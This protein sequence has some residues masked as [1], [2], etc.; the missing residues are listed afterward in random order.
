MRLDLPSI[1]LL[2]AVV[3]FVLA[4]FTISLGSI[5]LTALG[6]ACFAA[7]SLFTRGGLNLRM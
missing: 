2:A 7:S 1:P 6:L 3:L 4:A 5:G